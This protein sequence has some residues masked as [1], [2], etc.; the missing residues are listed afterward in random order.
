LPVYAL[1]LL[2]GKT[3]VRPCRAAQETGSVARSTAY[4]PRKR[5][6]AREIPWKEV[7]CH[8]RELHSGLQ[9][10]ERR[11]RTYAGHGT[12]GLSIDVFFKRGSQ[13]SKLL[14]GKSARYCVF[15]LCLH[16]IK[17]VLAKA[18]RVNTTLALL[19]LVTPGSALQAPRT[20]IQ[21][22]DGHIRT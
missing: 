10:T 5:F 18:L 8:G 14:L 19:E 15:G 17:F 22:A 6:K 21:H 16:S 11:L 4:E 13:N 12:R 3:I 1:A 9:G 20:E 7:G 2:L